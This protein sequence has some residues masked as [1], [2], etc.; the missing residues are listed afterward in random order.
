M[1]R[2]SI[3]RS[4]MPS[5]WIAMHTRGNG[6]N[7]WHPLKAKLLLVARPC[8]ILWSVAL[9]INSSGV[10]HLTTTLAGLAF[11][12][13]RPSQNL[14]YHRRKVLCSISW[15]ISKVSC[16][17][18]D[19]GKVCCGLRYLLQD[20]PCLAYSLGSAGDTTFEQEI[21]KRTSCQVEHVSQAAASLATRPLIP[22][23][24]GAG[25]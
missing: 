9:S 22:V 5:S 19:G 18:G 11:V 15:A 23:C 25:A 16:V 4:E 2:V 20:R 1:T 21:V 3:H 8:Q 13:S 24:G 14:W 10:C 17:E 12:H 6:T 7:S